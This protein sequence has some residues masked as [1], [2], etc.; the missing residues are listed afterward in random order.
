MAVSTL[1]IGL[2]FFLGYDRSDRSIVFFYSLHNVKKTFHG[3]TGRACVCVEMFILGV[4]QV[5]CGR[6]SDRSTRTKKQALLRH[7][8]R[9]R[10]MPRRRQAT[11]EV[12]AENIDGY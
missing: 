7:G 5:D 11:G 12:L 9:W 6:G 4:S 10:R 3:L 2:V 8:S 1:D